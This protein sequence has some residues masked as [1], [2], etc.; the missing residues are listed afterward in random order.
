[1]VNQLWQSDTN[2]YK[3]IHFLAKKNIANANQQSV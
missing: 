3:K 1:M 2:C